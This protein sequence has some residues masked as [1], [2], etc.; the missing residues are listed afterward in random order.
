MM[1]NTKFAALADA[2][3]INGKTLAVWL[4]VSPYTL[5]TYRSGVRKR[6]AAS[7]PVTV[8][9]A[10]M[11]AVECAHD[12]LDAGITPPGWPETK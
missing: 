12:M 5:S 1:D 4:D 9:G 3:P 7:T 11:R 10:V 2:L 8:P 6:G